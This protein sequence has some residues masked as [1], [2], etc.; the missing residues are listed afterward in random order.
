[1]DDTSACCIQAQLLSIKGMPLVSSSI[2]HATVGMNDLLTQ[3]SI[4]L[5]GLG[6]L[7]L[8]LVF[9]AQ[10]LALLKPPRRRGMLGGR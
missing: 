8:L 4:Y 6:C 3:A 5:P 7:L 2:I 10:Q 9:Q 1:V